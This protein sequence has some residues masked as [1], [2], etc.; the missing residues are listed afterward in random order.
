MAHTSVNMAEQGKAERVKDHIRIWGPLKDE[1]RWLDNGKDANPLLISIHRESCVSHVPRCSTNHALGRAAKVLFHADDVVDMNWRDVPNE[2]LNRLTVRIAKFPRFYFHPLDKRGWLY[3]VS[4]VSY[5]DHN[6]DGP[7][8]YR[9]NDT[10]LAAKQTKDIRSAVNEMHRLLKTKLH[11]T[12]D[13]QDHASESEQSLHSDQEGGKSEDE[14][15]MPFDPE[16]WLDVAEISDAVTGKDREEI[17]YMI[18]TSLSSFG[19]VQVYAN[20]PKADPDATPRV[21]A[22]SFDKMKEA[23]KEVEK[24]SEV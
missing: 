1:I 21:G 13:A 6:N 19:A 9:H 16:F 23:T 22:Y 12:P 2:A 17:K 20:E 15:M 14:D 18:M 8:D 24:G 11:P 10:L 4:I 3:Q 7:K 5:F